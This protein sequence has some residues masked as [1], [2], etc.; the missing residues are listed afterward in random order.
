M[1]D[2]EAG[3]VR[4]LDAA[5]AA[6]EFGLTDHRLTFTSFRALPSASNDDALTKIFAALQRY[7]NVF[8]VCVCVHFVQVDAERCHLTKFGLDSSG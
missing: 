6:D 4:L 5:E 2:C 7:T 1:K 8:T 3:P